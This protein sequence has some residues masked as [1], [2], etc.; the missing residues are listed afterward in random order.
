M[1]REQLADTEALAG[2]Y[3]LAID[4][5]RKLLFSDPKSVKLHRCMAE[6]YELQGDHGNEVACYQKASELAP[7]DL[8]VS[9]GLAGALAR[10]GRTNEA[11]TEFARVVNEHPENALALNNA[12]FFLAD[13]GGD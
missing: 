8:A 5:L 12:A 13:T 6:V 2:H 7:Q 3:N 9:L 10:A 11:R 4:H 1:L